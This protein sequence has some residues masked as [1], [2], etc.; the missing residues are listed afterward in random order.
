MWGVPC[1]RRKGRLEFKIYSRVDRPVPLWRQGNSVGSLKEHTD[2]S[3]RANENSL[4]KIDVTIEVDGIWIECD[5]T[6]YDEPC[7]IM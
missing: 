6:L 3:N 7:Q 1:G 5:R 2:I 4:P